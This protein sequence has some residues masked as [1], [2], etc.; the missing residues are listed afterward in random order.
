MNLNRMSE[1]YQQQ[2]GQALGFRL[3]SRLTGKLWEATYKGISGKYVM[4]E[5]GGQRE[6]FVEG[7]QDRYE[8]ADPNLT[9]ATTGARRAELTA[10]LETL[11]TQETLL[12]EQLEATKAQHITPLANQMDA[13]Q[14]E[15]DTIE[16]EL[17]T[18]D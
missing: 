8:F 11:T 9:E 6:A 18:L 12:E 15:M 13:L 17:D 16:A 1:L 7:D 10:K 3:R 2:T 5:C 14:R 4:V